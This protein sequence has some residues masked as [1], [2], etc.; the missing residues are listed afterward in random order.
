M[1]CLEKIMLAASASITIPRKAQQVTWLS[2]GVLSL[3]C[4]LLLFSAS[5]V[6]LLCVLGHI[7]LL[8]LSE[9]GSARE[10]REKIEGGTVK[11]PTAFALSTAWTQIQRSWAWVLLLLFF[12][13]FNVM[14]FSCASQLVVSKMLRMNNA[15]GFKDKESSFAW[16]RPDWAPRRFLVIICGWMCRVTSVFKSHVLCKEERVR[17]LFLWVAFVFLLL[18][19]LNILT[20]EMG[21]E[22]L[23]LWVAFVFVVMFCILNIWDLSFLCP[24]TPIW[25]RRC[26]GVCHDAKLGE[27]PV[28]HEGPGHALAQATGGK[29]CQ[30][31]ETVCWMCDAQCVTQ[32]CSFSCCHVLVSKPINLAPLAVLHVPAAASHWQ[33]RRASQQCPWARRDLSLVPAW[34]ALASVDPWQHLW[35][36]S[37]MSV[38]CKDQLYKLWHWS[39][40]IWPRSAKRLPQSPVLWHV[41]QHPG[42]GAATEQLPWTFVALHTSQTCAHLWCNAG[43]CA[44]W[45]CT[46]HWPDLRETIDICQG[47]QYRSSACANP[48]TSCA[49]NHM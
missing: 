9:P 28:G 21:L 8:Q 37:Q 22:N 10:I 11:K 26:A 30:R 25:H 1:L 44:S 27:G 34:Q 45:L 6:I 39:V 12:I 24:T 4:S 48:P 14:H 29:I 47:W 43:L 3:N 18:F 46:C 17:N 7:Y 38:I 33:L 31:Q 19:C 5:F 49:F 13:H 40:W 35:W 16:Q 32:Y 23:L 20:S 15:L 2:F 42:A 41:K 36:L